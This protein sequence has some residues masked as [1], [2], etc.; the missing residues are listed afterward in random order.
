L[1]ELIEIACKLIGFYEIALRLGRL[2]KGVLFD[3]L[4]LAFHQS[5]LPQTS[6][7]RSFLQTYLRQKFL[8]WQFSTLP[9]FYQRIEIFAWL[10]DRTTKV[11]ATYFGGCYA[12]GLPLT[13]RF[14]RMS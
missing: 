13:E 12:L 3:S 6:V 9:L 2:S 14:H 7:K 4:P 5:P 10:F 8:N 11:N 1:G